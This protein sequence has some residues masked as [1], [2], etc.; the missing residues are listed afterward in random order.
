M[1]TH[2][3]TILIPI[4]PF[5]PFL[6]C[7]YSLVSLSGPMTI[8]TTPP[9]LAGKKA[10]DFSRLFFETRP[11]GLSSQ[12]V[13]VRRQEIVIQSEH[14][15]TAAVT[16]GHVVIHSAYPDFTFLAFHTLIMVRRHGAGL[17]TYV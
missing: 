16:H 6:I 13:K 7:F 1:M 12:M 14:E 9:V 4:S 3:L 10:P 2:N 15:M 17:L 11:V 5:L 8:V